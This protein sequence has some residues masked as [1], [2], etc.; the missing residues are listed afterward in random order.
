MTFRR[1]AQNGWVT[2]EMLLLLVALITLPFWIEQVGLYRYLGVEILIW[3]IYGLGFNLLLGYSGLPSFGHG[4]FFGTGAYAFGLFQFWFFESLWLGIVFAIVAAGVAGAIV[5]CF[6][7]HR[8]GIY[9]AL[10]TIAFGQIF[11]FVSIKWHSVT[12]GED[13]LLNI[14]R[15]ALDL[16]FIS[17]YLNSN[18]ELY[19]FALCIFCVVVVFLWR[20]VHSTFGK[21]L[22]AVRQ[23]EERAGFIGY[24][25]WMFKWAAFSLS[26]AIAGLAGALFSMAQQGA[27]P[28]VMSLH[29]SGIIVMM[30]LIGGGFVSFWGPIIG[31][32][33]Y[34]LAREVLGIIT[35][36][37][38]LWFGLFFVLA[39]L[40][41][42]E[43]IAGAWQYWR[44]RKP[45]LAPGRN[46]G[47]H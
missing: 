26:A 38:L 36:A 30:T 40:F 1:I 9:F 19:Y 7:S 20:L 35:E 2:R 46:T 3:M 4:A 31:V 32:L 21:V 42:P 16:G 23:N 10:M 8:R 5:A 22:Q 14:P 18:T 12:G 43:G 33:V 24:N 45:A 13:G 17:I 6:L 28:D 37:W 47:D 25:V 11:W 27:Y 29:A 15:P 34:F 39:V 44:G 41:K